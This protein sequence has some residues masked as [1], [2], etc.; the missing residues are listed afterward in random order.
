MKTEF[1][2]FRRIMAKVVLLIIPFAL[3]ELAELFI[4]PI[5]TF[6]FRVW[7][8]ALATPYR[9]PG[10]FYP[11]LHVRKSRE[12]GSYYRSG[13][14]SLVQKKPVEWFTDAYG[15][16]NR[17]EIEKQDKYDIVIL[18][19]SDIVGSFLDQ[20]DTISEIIGFR[21]NKVCYSY[22]MGHDPI[23]LFFSD[24]RLE[25]K[26]PSL[27]IVESRVL[28]WEV[29]HSHLINFGERPD[30][31]LDVVDRTQEFSTNYYNPTRNLFLEK[32]ESKLTKQ[33]MF[34]WLKA[35]L[36]VDFVVP[37]RINSQIFVGTNHLAIIDGE[38]G[39]RPFNWVVNN[40][41][42]EPLPAESQPA[43]KIRAMG[44]SPYWLT[45]RFISSDSDGK[46]SIRFEARNS[47]SPSRHRVWIHEDGSYRSVGEF[48]A[49]SDWRKFKIPI[50]TNLGSILMFQIEQLDSWQWLLI[51]NVHMIG[52]KPLPLVRQAPLETPMGTWTW[53]HSKPSKQ[54]GRDV[55]D[56]RQRFVVGQGGP[57]AIN[58]VA[59]RTTLDNRSGHPFPCPRNLTPLDGS[60]RSLTIAE[61][62]YYFYHATKVMQRRALERGMDFIMF[63]MP[64]DN[65]SKLMPAIRQLRS[66]GVKVLAF[67]PQG[68][69]PSGVDDSWWWQKADSHWTEAAVRLT[70]DE[71]LRM[72]HGQMTQNRPFSEELRTKYD[73]GFPKEIPIE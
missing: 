44:P 4:L 51:R 39:W 41:V 40:I 56:C 10:G 20:K 21:S 6:T 42:I 43:M 36:A 59:T 23:S 34:H 16:R 8:A 69:W 55:H 46:I 73:R 35:S 58:P 37:A 9:Y 49:R 27:L 25:R 33:V 24:P 63:V 52:G 48:V 54:T 32:L 53:D 7:E 67:E 1:S 30:A 72:W 19:D 28:N 26:S 38:A 2:D 61:T 15:W 68:S 57:Q 3:L 65:I 5:D 22:S 62:E 17:P 11:N 50:T 71:I 70:A 29:N 60:G 64:G 66:E 47:L 18:G 14:P 31:F 13:D 45:E 12:Y